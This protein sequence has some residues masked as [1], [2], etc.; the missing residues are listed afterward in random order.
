MLYLPEQHSLKK[1]LE[2]WN[3]VLA[4]TAESDLL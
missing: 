4:E 3:R 2:H 1:M